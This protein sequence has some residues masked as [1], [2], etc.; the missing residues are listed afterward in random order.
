[1]ENL[2]LDW[3]VLVAQLVNFG[4][5]LV[6]LK[7]FLYKPL[8]KA[9]DERN[10]KISTALDDSKRIEEKLQNIEKKETE[11]LEL[12]REKAKKERE[13]IIEM[14]NKEREKMIEDAKVAANREVERGIEKLQTA[15]KEAV[16]VLSDKYMEEMVSELY[17]RFSERTKKHNYPMLKSILK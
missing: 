12:A 2:G 15:R 4:I 17:K 9:I 6:I 16:K 10:K 14:A 11:L 3:K 13:E 7:R 8:V 1:M 5:L